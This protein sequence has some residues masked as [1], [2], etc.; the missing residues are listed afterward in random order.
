LWFS[1]GAADG[2]NIMTGTFPARRSF[3]EGGESMTIGRWL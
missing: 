3:S 2:F 1:D